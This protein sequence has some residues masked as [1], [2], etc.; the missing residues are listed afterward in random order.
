MKRKCSTVIIVALV[1]LCGAITNAEQQVYTFDV[2]GAP[3]SYEP[4]WMPN[5]DPMVNGK[6]TLIIDSVKGLLTLKPSQELLN[7]TRYVSLHAHLYDLQHRY[8]NSDL[9]QSTICW[10]YYNHSGRGGHCEKD[11]YDCQTLT[12][13]ENWPWTKYGYS[14]DWYRT[15]SYTHLTLPTICSV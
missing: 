2:C 1:G 11:D 14:V 12:G 13:V 10:A 3:N 7:S 15:V 6:M 8:D 4:G 9:G 5:G